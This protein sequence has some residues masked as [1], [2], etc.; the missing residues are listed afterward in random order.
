VQARDGV[1]AADLVDWRPVQT[2]YYSHAIHNEYPAEESRD[3]LI[4]RIE[5]ESAAEEVRA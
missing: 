4:A 2:I 5:R 1:E 3:R